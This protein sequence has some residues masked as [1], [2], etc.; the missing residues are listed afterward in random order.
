MK[1]YYLQVNGQLENIVLS[2]VSQV[3]KAKGCLWQMQQYHWTRVTLRKTA[4]GRDREREGNQKLE[5][6]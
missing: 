1:L 2:E 6:G 5:C 4:H 3:Q